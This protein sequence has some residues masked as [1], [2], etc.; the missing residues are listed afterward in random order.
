MKRC[1]LRQQIGSIEKIKNKRQFEENFDI[2]VKL[3]G[4]AA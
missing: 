2:I 3:K 1:C 4:M